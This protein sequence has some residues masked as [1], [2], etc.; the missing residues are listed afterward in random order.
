M[1]GEKTVDRRSSTHSSGRTRTAP[2]WTGRG[3]AT[4]RR[5]GGAAYRHVLWAGS[6]PGER[7]R[8]GTHLRAEDA[9]AAQAAVAADCGC[10]AGVRPGAVDQQHLRQAGRAVLAGTVDDRGEGREQAA[11]AG[12]REHG[13]RGAAGP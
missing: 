2:D 7:A 11:A 10:S 4:A 1:A 8:G 5:R 12:D 9:R 6:G 13:Q 3:V